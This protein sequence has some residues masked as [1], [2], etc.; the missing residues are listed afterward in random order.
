M[1]IRLVMGACLSGVLL[2]APSAA[3]AQDTGDGFCHFNPTAEEC[4]EVEDERRDRDDDGGAGGGGAGDDEAD[5][6]GANDDEADVGGASDDDTEVLGET[7]TAP[8]SEALPRTGSELITAGVLAAGLLAA[9]G[10]A[11]AVGRRRN[12]GDSQVS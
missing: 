7:L 4:T 9:G 2:L 10:L 6:G 12:R 1:R 11:L 3:L 5:V 8:D